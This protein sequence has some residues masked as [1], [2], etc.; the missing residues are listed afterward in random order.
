MPMKRWFVV[1]SLLMDGGILVFWGCH[2][3]DCAANEV[4]RQWIRLF[5]VASLLLSQIGLFVLFLAINFIVK[6]LGKQT[7]SKQH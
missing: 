2:Y 5:A 6:A 1:V 3:Y 4:A 7:K